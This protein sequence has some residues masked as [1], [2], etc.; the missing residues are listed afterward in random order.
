MQNPIF[1]PQPDTSGGTKKL[2]NTAPHSGQS[3]N[4]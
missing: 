1:S 3:E 2:D 4:D